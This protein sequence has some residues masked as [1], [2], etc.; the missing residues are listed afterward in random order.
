[1]STRRGARLPLTFKWQRVI[2]R[3]WQDRTPYAE[4][5]YEAAVRKTGSPVVAWLDRVEL[6]KSPCKNPAKNSQKTR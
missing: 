6:G 5:T 3:C 1:M 2:F 4:K